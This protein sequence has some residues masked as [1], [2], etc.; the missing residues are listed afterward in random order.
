[1]PER[2]TKA[3]IAKLVGRNIF[4]DANILIYIFWPTG[5]NWQEKEYS[6]MLSSLIRQK[7]PL[8]VDN[9]IISEIYNRT[10]RLEFDKVAER[11]HRYINPSEFKNFRN[12]LE[13][14]QID[15]DISTVLKDKI[16]KNFD[17]VGKSYF[18]TDINKLL[19]GG[20]LDYSDRV[21]ADLCESKSAI[22]LTNDGDFIDSA[23]PILTANKKL[24]NIGH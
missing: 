17:I 8:I 19:S 10:F 15:K 24:L 16:L 5:S 21:I 7:N 22:L 20:S 23:L 11:E 13:G 1:M 6:S 9:T 2:Y 4:F 3:D 18:K 14:K 12:S